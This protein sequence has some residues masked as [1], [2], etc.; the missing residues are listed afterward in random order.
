VY[1]WDA[2][3]WHPTTDRFCWLL[4]LCLCFLFVR[5]QLLHYSL[6]HETDSLNSSRSAT[7]VVRNSSISHLCAFTSDSA[8]FLAKSASDICDFGSEPDVVVV[9]GGS[10]ALSVVSA[11]RSAVSSALSCSKAVSGAPSGNRSVVAK[12]VGC[13]FSA[14]D[15]TF[16]TQGGGTYEFQIIRVGADGLVQDFAHRVGSVHDQP[17]KLTILIP[18]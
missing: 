16:C 7:I 3:K 8:A 11:S 12:G 5:R 15:T 2:F 18:K 1:P 17:P 4:P 10:E 9:A 14:L 13:V 6:V